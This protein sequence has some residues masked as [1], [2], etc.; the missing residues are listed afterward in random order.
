M[1][2]AGCLVPGFHRQLGFFDYIRKK[3]E[4]R[5]VLVDNEEPSDTQ[6]EQSATTSVLP[7]K[8]CTLNNSPLFKQPSP[9]VTIFRALPVTSKHCT[10]MHYLPHTDNDHHEDCTIFEATPSK[11]LC[12]STGIDPLNGFCSGDVSMV[13]YQ[14][15]RYVSNDPTVL[16]TGNVNV[17]LCRCPSS[18]HQNLCGKNANMDGVFRCNSEGNFDQIKPDGVTLMKGFH[19][20]PEIEHLDDATVSAVNRPTYR[21]CNVDVNVNVAHASDIADFDVT[22][23]GQDNRYD[24]LLHARDNVLEDIDNC[25]E[26]ERLITKSILPD[27]DLDDVFNVKASKSE[28]VSLQ[29][30][31][32]KVLSLPTKLGT[33]FVEKSAK[34]RKS[35]PRQVAKLFQAKSG[36][37]DIEM[38]TFAMP[39]DKD[40]D[41][42]AELTSF[43][44]GKHEDSGSLKARWKRFRSEKSCKIEPGSTKR[45]SSTQIQCRYICENIATGKSLVEHKTSPADEKAKTGTIQKAVSTPSVTSNNL[46]EK[47]DDVLS[48]CDGVAQRPSTLSLFIKTSEC[49]LQG[50]LA[51]PI[52]ST[53]A[54]DAHEASLLICSKDNKDSN[55]TTAS[56]LKLYFSGKT[57][58]TED[59][60]SEEGVRKVQVGKRSQMKSYHSQPELRTSQV[61]HQGGV[62]VLCQ[63]SSPEYIVKQPV[64]KKSPSSCEQNAPLLRLKNRLFK[65][66]APLLAGGKLKFNLALPSLAN[67]S[68]YR[69][70]VNTPR[71]QPC[72]QRQSD[73]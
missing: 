25:E 2:A 4:S 69:V 59:M 47:S 72:S 18:V 49:D 8:N 1:S 23:T 67:S 27:E 63:K 22:D 61:E 14:S 28:P 21:E 29:I 43:I 68:P 10:Y 11:S 13:R 45:M 73:G 62:P 38:E 34:E 26:N 57:K 35:K 17:G 66:K 31:A 54:P 12:N 50:F 55:V 37:D 5:R 48:T 46:A 60:E 30:A 44:Q 3:S 19:S 71:L 24:D 41:N 70:K 32:Y 7:Y 58:S 53:E 40:T 42:K 65:Q 52:E 16:S 64:I 15:D 20:E 56:R 51:T 39:D 33:H 9:L 36:T 6:V